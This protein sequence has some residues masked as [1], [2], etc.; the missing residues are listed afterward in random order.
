VQQ[1]FAPFDQFVLDHRDHGHEAAETRAADFDKNPEQRGQRGR[2]CH[3]T[4][5]V[6]CIHDWAT[7]VSADHGTTQVKKDY[8][9]VKDRVCQS[10]SPPDL[11]NMPFVRKP[12]TVQRS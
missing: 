2:R 12:F 6:I 3:S 9:V 4:F 5:H 11:G 8:Q 7:V 10:A 1:E